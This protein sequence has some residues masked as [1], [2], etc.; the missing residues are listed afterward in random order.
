M[1]AV[2][3]HKYVYYKCITS[4]VKYTADKA[5]QKQWHNYGYNC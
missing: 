4:Q 1:L 3:A 5:E 2:L